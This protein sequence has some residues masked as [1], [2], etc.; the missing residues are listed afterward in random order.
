MPPA[1]CRFVTVYRSRAERVFRE[2]VGGLAW[3]SLV[4]FADEPDKLLR[5]EELGT[6]PGGS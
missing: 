4:W 2:T 3:N 6:R 5:L 1:R